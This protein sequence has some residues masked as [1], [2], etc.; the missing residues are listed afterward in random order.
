MQFPVYLGHSPPTPFAAKGSRDLVVS[1][2]F[3]VNAAFV[4]RGGKPAQSG[5]MDRILCS[6]GC[7]V[8]GQ[9]EKSQIHSRVSVMRWPSKQTLPSQQSKVT[10]S[11]PPYTPPLLHQA[12]RC[13][14]R[15][16]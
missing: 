16:A 7:S 2:C 3:A 6:S 9:G 13:Q 12:Q 1:R 11:P 10:V 8:N 15:Q 4:G 5:L 14:A